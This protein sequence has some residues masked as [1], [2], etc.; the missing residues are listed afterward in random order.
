MLEPHLLAVL[1]EVL[2]LQVVL[3]NDRSL[4]SLLLVFLVP[5]REA[6]SCCHHSAEPRDL[7]QHHLPYLALAP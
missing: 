4:L 6:R 5:G 7:A 3:Q 1:E 2:E